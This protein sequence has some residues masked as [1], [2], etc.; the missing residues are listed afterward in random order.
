M[1]DA[2]IGEIRIV[3]WAWAPAGWL[4]CNGQSLLVSQYQ[5]LFAVITNRYG[6]DGRVNF[7]LPDLRGNTA[8]CQG[9][10]T[11][12]TVRVLAQTYGTPTVTLNTN[13][14]PPHD[15][16]LLAGRSTAGTAGYTSTPGT[17]TY[18]GRS[19]VSTDKSY[20]A[21]T[22]PLVQLSSAAV[23]PVGTGG[24]HENRQPFLV[25][26]YIICYDGEFPIRP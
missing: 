3:P 4:L 20:I 17:N 7:N 16:T 6:G 21:Q 13:Q 8:A 25:M 11:G 19:P 14:I 22:T 2:Y 9:Q 10:G 18:I 1:D 5:A 23:S 15:H 26:N 12:L 24:A